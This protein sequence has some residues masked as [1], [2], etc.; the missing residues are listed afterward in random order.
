MERP[1]IGIFGLTGCAGDQIVILNC[2]D[3]LLTL[4]SAVDIRDFLTGSS[5]NDTACELDVSFVEGTVLNK[6]DEERL[7]AI[8]RRSSLL[9]ATGTCAAWGGVPAMEAD[10][11]REEIIRRVYGDSTA[12]YDIGTP[13]KLSDVVKVDAAISGC[14]IEKDQFLSAVADLLNDNLPLLVD[15][16]VCVECKMKEN[17]CLLEKGVV[18]C[19]PLTVGGCKARCPS[20][21]IP[22]VGCHGP[23]KE[24]NYESQLKMLKEKGF[25]EVDMARK[26]RSFAIAY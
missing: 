14:P 22:C 2:E 5:L 21:G 26:L 23:V 9:I 19:G 7:K 13:R 24:A 6:R 11:P 16:P 12:W 15:T 3:E 4:V 1:K 25:E 18:C 20:L 17:V 8:R 10:A